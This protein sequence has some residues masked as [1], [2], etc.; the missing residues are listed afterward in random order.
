[1]ITLPPQPLPPSN[2]F[3]HLVVHDQLDDIASLMDGKVAVRKECPRRGARSRVCIARVK[4]PSPV[5]FR[6]T[7]TAMPDYHFLVG[8]RVIL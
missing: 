3:A 2:S 5:R 1:M 8:A 6:V 4:G 7:I